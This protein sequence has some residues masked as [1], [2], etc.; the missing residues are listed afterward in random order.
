[1]CI[2]KYEDKTKLKKIWHQFICIV[3]RVKLIFNH[4]FYVHNTSNK[5]AH[6]T[7]IVNKYQGLTFHLV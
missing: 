6:Q 1:M 3:H 7:V 2:M 4:T 5:L